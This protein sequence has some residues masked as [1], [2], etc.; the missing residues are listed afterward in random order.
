M[1][2]PPACIRD[3]ASVRSF[4][5][6]SLKVYEIERVVARWTMQLDY[7]G[8]HSLAAIVERTQYAN[9]WAMSDGARDPEAESRRLIIINLS[10]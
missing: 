5:V 1:L 8:L 6:I 10:A 7:W 9:C 4:A 3:P 2:Q